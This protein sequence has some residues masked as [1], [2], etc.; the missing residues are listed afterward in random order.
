VKV[1]VKAE[2]A[3]SSVD[4]VL[5]G[6]SA[7]DILAQ[8]KNKVAAK[9]GWKGLFLNAMSPMTFAQMIVRKYNEQ[10][11]AH[12]DIPNSPEEF[13]TLGVQL[14]YLSILPDS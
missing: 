7:G 1:R 6:S 13:V 11:H 3:G 2:I 4:E 9:L 14:G 5:D 8:A 10:Y 12:Y